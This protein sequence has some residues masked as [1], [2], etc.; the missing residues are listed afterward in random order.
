MSPIE[1]AGY[2][3]RGFT[4]DGGKTS[5]AM[6]VSKDAP[7]KPRRSYAGQRPDLN[8]Q[9]FRSRMEANVARYANFLQ[10]RHEIDHWEYE[11]DEFEFPVK[12]GSGKY[13][14]PDFKIWRPDSSYY[15][16]EVK[17]WMDPVSATKL[18]RMAK[19]YPE[20]EIV[21]IDTHWYRKVI[22]PLKKLLSGWEDGKSG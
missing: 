21:L 10:A 14:K 22:V 19:Y 13:Y 5:F 18:K 6:T 4:I 3:A 7:K 12:R 11:V 2:L 20:K 17:G 8:N 9:Y 1:L 15:Y 16:W